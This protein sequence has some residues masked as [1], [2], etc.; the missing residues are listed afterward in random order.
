MPDLTIAH[1]TPGTPVTRANYIAAD[2]HVFGGGDVGTVAVWKAGKLAAEKYLSLNAALPT[3]AGTI[4]AAM[5]ADGATGYLLK[6]FAGATTGAFADFQT[7]GALSRFR[8]D[9]TGKVRINGNAL[10][11]PSDTI[12][13]ATTMLHLGAPEGGNPVILFDAAGFGT[14][15]IGRR[16][17]GTFAIPAVT[18]AAATILGIQG[19]GYDTTNGY[20]G[21]QAA[22]LLSTI[23]AWTNL[24][25]STQITFQ[26]TPIGSVTPETPITIRRGLQLGSPALGDP[27]FGSLAAQTSVVSPLLTGP[28]TTYNATASVHALYAGGAWSTTPVNPTILVPVTAFTYPGGASTGYF[29]ASVYVT[30]QTGAVQKGGGMIV[31]TIVESTAPATGAAGGLEVGLL[32]KLDGND[33]YGVLAIINNDAAVATPTGAAVWAIPRG[34]MTSTGTVDGFRAT[35]ELTS[36]VNPANGL[37][38]HNTETTNAF[39]NGVHVASAVS[40]GVVV[41]GSTGAVYINPTK[42]FAYI[43]NNGGFVYAFYV[44]NVGAVVTERLIVSPVGGTAPAA[45]GAVRLPVLGAVVSRNV[46]DTDGVLIAY[47]SATDQ[48]TVG[49]GGLPVTLVN[50]A[51]PNADAT[52]NLGSA[53]FRWNNIRVRQLVMPTGA[54]FTPISLTGYSVT[55]SGTSALVSW[56][57]TLNT[58]GDVDVLDV[59]ITQTASG[60]NTTLLKLRDGATNYLTLSKAG[61]L[62]ARASLAAGVASAATG[63]VHLFHASSAF[64]L[65]LASAAIATADRTVTFPDPGGADSVVY[66]TLAQTLVGKTFT[67]PTINGGTHTAITSLGIRSTG[68]AFDLTLASSEVLTAGR[69]L[70]I[71]M[72]DTARTLTFSGNPTLADWFD[73]SVKA[74]ASPTFVSPVIANLAP[75]AD[76]TITQNA[77]AAFKSENTG[78]V[79]D[80]LHLKT[81]FVG[82]GI[83]APLYALH[84]GGGGQTSVQAAAAGIYC[85]PNS[86][87]AHISVEQS[88]GVEGG[89]MAFSNATFYMGTWSNNA[90]V[91]RTNNANRITI[92]AAGDISTTSG[93]SLQVGGT[94]A[95][96]TTAG[97]NRFD[98]FDGTAPVGTLANGISL[99]STA[100]ELRVMDAGG[101]A[102][103]LSPHDD[104]GYWV[105]DSTHTPTGRRLL[106]DVERLLRAVNERLGLNFIHEFAVN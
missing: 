6:A 50:G 7:S 100:G 59:N 41:G 82:I 83:A 75:G 2:N 14:N 20:S 95:R 21:S 51:V 49:G 26:T 105:F 4:S 58:S 31:Q 101:V 3:I 57:G 42:P 29:G 65:I 94:A 71:V 61:A 78:A 68:A 99:Y 12:A 62:M 90:L 53:S 88:G 25:H 11:L 89:M 66:V 93:L 28:G 1:A 9:V 16:S 98:L 56:A 52:Q 27:G 55:G 35:S 15:L 54:D 85:N 103:L 24:D 80:T 84:I 67:A 64:K 70:S 36:A 37:K 69:A 19:R 23:S 76:F 10:A 8:V 60:A 47:V 86:T 32:N 48:V 72:G 63:A 81:G 45:S 17:G 44:D 43:P 33:G 96:A 40:H 5:G 91:I 13:S 30:Y 79:V 102:T 104:D 38:V 92:G 97:T 22:I 34:N 73:Q 106:I 39:L 46:G 87:S 18:A 74:A 77:V